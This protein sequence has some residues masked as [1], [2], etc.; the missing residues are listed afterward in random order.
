MRAC[1]A[2]ARSAKAAI[3]RCVTTVKPELIDVDRILNEGRWTGYQQWLVFLTAVTII[4]DGF[5]NQLLRVALPTIM[6][7]WAVAPGRFAPVGSL[8]YLRMMSGG[9]LAGY[10]GDRIGRRN[11]LLWCLAVFGSATI[12]VAMVNDVGTLGILRLVAGIGPRGGVPDAAVPGGVR[13]R[14]HRRGDGQ[15]RRHAWDPAAGGGY[16][17]RGSD[18]ERRGAGGRVRAAP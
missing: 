18:A 11:A 14:H 8:R 6:R 1:L 15:R 5:D 4:F 7:E 17:P 12:V 13:L 10:A 16:R 3:L 9:T 2:E